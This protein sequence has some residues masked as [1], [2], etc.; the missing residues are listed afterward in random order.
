MYENLQ[1]LRARA[2]ASPIAPMDLPWIWKRLRFNPRGIHRPWTPRCYTGAAPQ[3]SCPVRQGSP[4]AP[5]CVHFGRSWSSLLLCGWR[6]PFPGCSQDGSVPDQRIIRKSCNG[7]PGAR[8]GRPVIYQLCDGANWYFIQLQKHVWTYPAFCF[9]IF[10]V[11]EI[12]GPESP[13]NQLLPMS[14]N[15]SWSGTGKKGK[16]KEVVEHR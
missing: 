2:A 9:G 13:T 5:W 1:L 7:L 11:G 4:A 14:R 8:Y 3:P 15:K 6:P 10:A 16:T 12:K